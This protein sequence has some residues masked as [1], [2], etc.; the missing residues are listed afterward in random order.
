[1]MPALTATAAASFVIADD[2]GSA[3]V[4]FY[5]ASNTVHYLYH[6]DEDDWVQIP[7]GSF[8][9]ALAAGACGTFLP[10][11]KNYTA[12]GGS[13]TTVTVAAASFNLNGFVKDKTI[14]FLT[15]TAAN[16]GQRRTVTQILSD[17]GIG[18]ITLTLDSALPAV[19]A[20]TDTFR[21]KSGSFF[22]INAGTLAATNYF[23]RFDVGTLSWSDLSITGLSATWGTDGKMVS[24]Y[25][26]TISYDSGTATS[27]SSTTLVVSG[28]NWGT[29]Q[30]KNYQVRIT[31]GTGIGQVRVI[32][33]NNATTLTF[34][35]GATIDAT[36]QFTIEGDENAI[37]L[38]GNNAVTMYK[39][40]ISGNSWSTTSPTTARAGAPVAGMTATFVGQT[41]DIGWAD[42]TNI[43]DGRYIFSVRGGS[44]VID[45]YDIASVTWLPT[46]GVNYVGTVTFATGCSAFWSERYIYLAK[47]GSATVPQRFYKFSVRGNYLEPLTTDW[48]LGGVALLGSKMWIK[49]LSSAGAVKWLYCLQSTSTNLRRIMLF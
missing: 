47:E 35:S 42:K 21:I 44:T 20:N 12:T 31:A 26:G 11:S 43:K 32:T 15:G 22:I 27:G 48:Y 4:A 34:A 2:S 24:P 45:R 36:S 25:M 49:N 40:S 19:V 9:V 37:Y 46:T 17:S 29:D 13:T 14:E 41:G 3:N 38:L 23:K 5:M 6:H 30:W 18:T 16:I 8:A 39:Y 33:T 7:S 28:R 10:W 1:M